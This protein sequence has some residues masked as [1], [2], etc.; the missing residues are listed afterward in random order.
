LTYLLFNEITGFDPTVLTGSG[1]SDGV[2]GDAVFDSLVYNDLTSGN[3]TPGTAESMTSQDGVNWVIKLRP[4]IK[5][6]DGTD[7]NAAAVKFNWDR[8]ANP[9]N[10]SSQLGNV[11]QM[12]Y[13]ATDAVTLK[14]A[15]KNQNNQLPRL[16]ARALGFI[17]S[18]KALDERGSSFMLNPVGAGAFMLAKGSDWTR[19]SQMT[20]TR[21]PNYWNK[22]L[23]YVD[24]LV[25]KTILDEDQRMNSFLNGEGNLT[26]TSVIQ[27]ADR[28]RKSGY[29]EATIVMNGGNSVVFNTTKAPFNDV[30]VRKAF[31][32][33]LDATKFN[34]D[35]LGGLN[36]PV[37][38]LFRSDSPF[39]DSALKL[40]AYDPTAAQ[41]LWD[42]LAPRREDR[43]RSHWVPSRPRRTGRRL[44]GYKRTWVASGTYRSPWTLPTVQ[45]RSL[46]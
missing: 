26:Y 11:T 16:L 41:K 35:I 22:P 8:H 46:G 42:D 13:D 17:G 34:K 3:V 2:R 23:P 21:N 37:D 45:R 32:L 40:P 31:E 4:G 27:T 12:T 24:Q 5:F 18:P 14:L 25:I 43:S 36:P 20:L 44:S 9:S 33:S 39:Y 1:G 10:R 30:R 6:T 15:L 29:G 7:Y 38:T 19:D 28:L